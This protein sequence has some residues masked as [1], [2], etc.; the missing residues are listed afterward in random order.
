[1][2][3]YRAPI[4]LTAA[5]RLSDFANGCHA[6]LD[7]W[8]KRRAL[9]AEG[10]SARTYVA[11]LTDTAHDVVGYHCIVAANVERAALPSAK[12]RRNMPDDVPLL[13]IRRLAVDQNH[14]GKGLGSSLV[15]DAV[16]RAVAASEVVGARAIAAHAIDDAAAFFCNRHAFVEAPITER[17]MILPIETARQLTRG[18]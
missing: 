14:Q 7:D 15:V 16:S 10:V 11:T 13:L 8:L 5:H 18:G 4:H 6:S 1:M 17:L 2:S 3:V 9:T 12:L